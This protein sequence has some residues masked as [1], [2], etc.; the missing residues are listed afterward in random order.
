MANRETFVDEK[1][2]VCVRQHGVTVR[3][4]REILER[5]LEEAEA[6]AEKYRGWLE[7]LSQHHA[8]LAETEPYYDPSLPE[9]VASH[10]E[11][12]RTHRH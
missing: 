2:R 1:G 6:Q 5:K 4:D 7:L 8:M 9:E 3:F 12:Q 11:W 10:L